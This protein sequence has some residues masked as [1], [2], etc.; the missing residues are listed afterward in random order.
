[1]RGDSGAYADTFC[2]CC[3]VRVLG[4]RGMFILFARRMR[5]ISRDR[6]EDVV[7]G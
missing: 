7:M 3:C 5:S 2:C 4:G 1:M 6:V